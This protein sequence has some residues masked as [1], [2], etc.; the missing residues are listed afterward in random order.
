MPGTL[1]PADVTQIKALTAQLRAAADRIDQDIDNGDPLVFP[2]STVGLF[3]AQDAVG[4]LAYKI[5][6]EMGEQ[7]GP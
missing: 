3:M 6:L 1:T 2:L 7:T 4:R 5:G